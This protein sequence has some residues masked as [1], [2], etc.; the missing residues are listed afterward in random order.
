MQKK[1]SSAQKAAKTRQKNLRS[2]RKKSDNNLGLYANLAHKRK[3]KKDAQTRKKAEYLAS[4]PKN[5]FLRFLYRLHPKRFFGYWFSKE[6][7]IM[8]LKILG[9]GL[10]AVCILVFALFAYYQKDLDQI[11]PGELAKRVQTTVNKYYDRNG[12][13]LWEDKGDGDYKLVVDSSEINDYMKKATV[14]IEDREFYNH[15]GV[16][17]SAIIRATVNNFRGG[18]TQGGSTL[19]QQLIKQVYFSDEAGDRSFKGHSS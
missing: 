8:A 13:L 10:A 16:D 11:R 6:G 3:T 5:P 7:G 14:A 17:P 19:T 1:V 15:H 4:L 18:A 9:G 2:T 12:E